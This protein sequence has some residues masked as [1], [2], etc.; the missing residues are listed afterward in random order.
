MYYHGKGTTK[1]YQKS[2]DWLKKSSKQGHDKS[3][4]YLAYMYYIGEGTTQNYQKA[5]T[6]FLIANYFE[7]LISSVTEYIN[8]LEQKLS[9]QAITEAQ[10]EAD[11]IIQNFKR[12]YGDK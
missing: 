7:Y 3:H 1:N 6:H 11:K 10:N 12:T 4:F 8:E 9:P 5:Y 2:F